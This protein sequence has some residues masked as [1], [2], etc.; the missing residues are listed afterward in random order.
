MSDEYRV[1]VELDDP[2]HGY[3]L[4]ERLRSFKLDDQVK[5]R[6]GDQVTVTRNGSLVLLYASSEDDA[7]TAS[8][9]V[10]ELLEKDRLSATVRI[11]RW[12]PAQE[13]W[14][15][16]SVPLPSTPDEEAGERAANQDIGPGIP[17]G[18]LV[19][20][21]AYEPRFLRDLGL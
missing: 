15:D 7:R 6:L 19:W 18:R 1:E 8:Q 2:E 13:E 14:L 11:N 10:T 17:D 20:A 9:V 3:S 21:E 4:G 16:V 12:H 5:D